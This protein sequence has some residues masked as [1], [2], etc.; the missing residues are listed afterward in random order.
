VLVSFGHVDVLG[1]QTGQKL[2]RDSDGGL[3]K[4][5]LGD[6]VPL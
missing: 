1:P 5:L 3:Q 6:L 2:S 4:S